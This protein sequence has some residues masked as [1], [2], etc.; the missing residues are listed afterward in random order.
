VRSALIEGRKLYRP[1]GRLKSDFSDCSRARPG[2]CRSAALQQPRI[3]AINAAMRLAQAAQLAFVLVAAAAV[4][5]FVRTGIDAERRRLCAPL[6]ALRPDY[7]AHNRLESLAGQTVRG[8]DFRG[9]ALILNFWSK[10]CRPCLE[11]LPSFAELARLLQPRDDVRL[12]TIST[13]DS[14]EDVAATLQAVLADEPPFMV[15]VDPEAEVV[16]GKFGTR[17]FPETWLIDPR[18]VIRARFD[19][20]RD[21]SEPVAV[22]LCESLLEPASCPLEFFRGDPVGPLAGLCE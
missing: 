19:G 15:L 10:H 1:F 8:S 13:D 17:L 22:D 6:C 21:W 2:G 12:V 4:Y 3:R 9:K 14:P 11:E 5:G 16:T 7:S 18:G 20:V